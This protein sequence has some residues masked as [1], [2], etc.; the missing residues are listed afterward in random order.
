MAG[1]YTQ[2]PLR[3]DDRWTAARMQQGRVLLDH[4]WNLN[5]DAAARAVREAA[6]DAI[7]WAGVVAGSHAFEMGVTASGTL[8]LT[9]DAGVMWVDGLAA[10]APAPFAYLDQEGIAALPVGGSVLVYLDVF[11][12]HVQPAEDPGDLVDPALGTIDTTARTR[13]GYRVRVAPTAA[14]TC[15]DAWAGLATIADSTG[16]LSV[17]RVAAS[18]PPDPCAPPGDPLAQ[19]PDGL[20]LV[21]VLDQGSESTARFA[22]SFEDGANAVPIVS[23][24]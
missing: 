19:V 11:D 24:V 14:T 4:D 15:H 12:E 1:D 9:V 22:W 16:R 2:V 20:L 18:P 7:G 6:R 23:V 10:Y 21:E 13:V 17:T 8:D 3:H 5:I